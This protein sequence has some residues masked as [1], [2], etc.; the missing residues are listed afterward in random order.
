MPLIPLVI[1]LSPSDY[2]LLTKDKINAL[3]KIGLLLEE[4]GNNSY[5]VIQIPSWLTEYNEKEY[6]DDLINQIIHK[7]YVDIAFLRKHT[8][9]TMSCKASLKAHDYLNLSE[10]Q[11]LLDNLYNCENPSCCPHGRPTI[12]SFTKYQLEKLFKRTGV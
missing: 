1:T 11:F 12:I 8:I 7:D 4:F 10:M 5:K 3:E 2:M 6:I 9:A